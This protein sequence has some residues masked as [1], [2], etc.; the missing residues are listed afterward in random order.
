MDSVMKRLMGQ[1]PQNFGART[2][3]D[4]NHTELWLFI[5]AI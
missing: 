5:L 1:Y 4:K 2:A 3:P